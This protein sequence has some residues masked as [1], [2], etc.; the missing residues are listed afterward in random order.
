LTHEDLAP[1]IW[2][3]P[4]EIANNG[5][6]DDNNGYIDDINGY[7]VADNDNNPNPPTNASSSVFSHGTHC[8]GIAS[9]RSDNGIGIASPGFVSKIMAVKTKFNSSTGATLERAYQGLEYAI[10]ANPTIISMSWGGYSYSQTYQELIDVAISKGIILVAAAGNADV[11]FPMYPA[12]YNGVISVGATDQ[13]DMKASFSNYGTSIDIMAPGVSI[14]S[15][16]ATTNSSYGYYSGTSMAC[17]IV[18]GICALLK[19]KKPS[20]TPSQI[21]QCLER[22]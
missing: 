7:D 16:F 9:A 21:E 12:G 2:V 5:I 15:S 20:G 19:S 11:D 8:A 14:W 18:A 1:N 3:N 4:N 6:D 17:P 22:A 10:A 13:N